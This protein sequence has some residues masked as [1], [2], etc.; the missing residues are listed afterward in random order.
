MVNKAVAMDMKNGNS[1][2]QYSTQ[3]EMENVNIAF[4]TILEGEK[5]PNGY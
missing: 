2:W 4:Q 1:L 3:K 5:P